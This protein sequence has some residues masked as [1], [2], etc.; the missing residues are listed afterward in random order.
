MDDANF[1]DSARAFLAANGEAVERV[2][3][4]F[5]EGG[6][7]NADLDDLVFDVAGSYGAD[8]ANL[9]DDPDAQEAAIAVY[10][11]QASEINNGPAAEQVAAVLMGHGMEE[12]ER[13]V[14]AA[15]P[16]SAPRA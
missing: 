2:A 5:A 9:T 15:L 13:L 1:K 11:G 7:D 10:E 6:G 8:A 12:G 4:A 16:A 3:A 14:M